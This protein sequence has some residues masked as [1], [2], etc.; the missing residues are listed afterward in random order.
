MKFQKYLSETLVPEWKAAY[1]DYKKLKK[2]LKLLDN[3]DNDKFLEKL[4]KEL[5]K[6][7]I[8]FQR[9]VRLLSGRFAYLETNLHHSNNYEHGHEHRHRRKIDQKKH[10]KCMLKEYYL[11]CLYLVNFQKLDRIAFTK[12]VKKYDKKFNENLTET[13]LE[14]YIN[15]EI[16][17]DKRPTEFLKKTEKFLT[18][19]NNGDKSKTLKFL[20]GKDNNTDDEFCFFRVGFL[21]GSSIPLIIFSVFTIFKESLYTGIWYPI[22]YM[23]G[24]IFI[25]I[26]SLF[27]F[28]FDV[29]VWRKYRIN[30]IFIFELNWGDTLSFKQI[31]ECASIMLFLWSIFVF[32][33]IQKVAFIPFYSL[34]LILVG[35]FTTILLLPFPII[36]LSSRKWFLKTIFNIFTPGFRKVYFKDFFITDLLISLTFFWTSLYVTTCFYASSATFEC[37]PRQ[38]WFTPVLICIP[39]YIRF[40][41]CIR[42]YYDQKKENTSRIQLWNA[43]KYLVATMSVFASQLN[44]FTKFFSSTVIWII[45]ALF[46]TVYSFFW[47]FEIDWKVRSKDKLL[48]KKV[49]YGTVV[50]N[51]FLRL[52]WTLSISTFLLFD[53]TLLSFFFGCLEVFRRYMWA[54]FRLELEHTQN[55]E[56]YRAIKDIPLLE[57]V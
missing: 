15:H 38:S 16:F 23:Y 9:Q 2:Y 12:I 34:P 17:T 45:V 51:L 57:N 48:P 7:I 44:V 36:Y 35:L 47:D 26:L 56:N 8:F 54:L 40:I 18:E 24:G 28:S 46:S 11:F 3:T 21:V 39:F 6:N 50:A 10:I 33:T 30:Y 5:E 31:M 43:G 37:F 14:K 55:A 29:Y 53:Q 49:M 42:K 27:G 32:T 52:N 13:S 25:V 4:D 20:R 1:F 41:Q 22:L 19:Y